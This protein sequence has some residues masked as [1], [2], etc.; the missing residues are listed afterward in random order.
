MDFIKKHLLIKLLVI[1]LLIFVVGLYFGSRWIVV[2]YNRYTDWSK[3]RQG[4]K[5]AIDKNDKLR[6]YYQSLPKPVLSSDFVVFQMSDQKGLLLEQ[7]QLIKAVE[8][9]VY[10]GDQNVIKQLVA[11]LPFEV[12]LN[13]PEES[14]TSTS[15]FIRDTVGKSY[16]I[17]QNH[18]GNSHMMPNV[19]AGVLTQ[20]SPVLHEELHRF[21]VDKPS[22]HLIYLIMELISYNEPHVEQL[23]SVSGE[24]YIYSDEGSFFDNTDWYTEELVC[25]DVLAY[26]RIYVNYK[27]WPTIREQVERSFHHYP[28]NWLDSAVMRKLLRVA[29]EKGPEVAYELF[30]EWLTTRTR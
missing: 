22:P 10:H 16:S 30:R 15:I 29:D 11:N 19:P 20:I 3:L 23:V 12:E 18:W 6:K 27:D 5:A 9:Y 28:G 17:L 13:L 21:A 25:R 4:R 14:E 8:W 7:E 2:G 26:L 1:L 24:H